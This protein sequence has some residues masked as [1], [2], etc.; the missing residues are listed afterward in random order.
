MSEAGLLSGALRYRKIVPVAVEF[1]GAPGLLAT[2]EGDV[3][4]EQGDALLTGVAGERWPVRREVFLRLYEPSDREGYW[5]KRVTVRA[6]RMNAAFTVS[7]RLGPQPVELRGEA[8]DWLLEDDSGERA[9]VKHDI[10]C[11]TYEPI[12]PAQKC[13]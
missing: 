10:F 13:P 8:G 7:L 2:L 5:R 12:D 11:R 6:V 3:P 4:Y 9:I 1:A